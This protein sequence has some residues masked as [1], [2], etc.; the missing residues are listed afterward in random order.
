MGLDSITL[1]A[2]TH[3]ADKLP[4]EVSPHL[5]PLAHIG[6]FL[7]GGSRR[8]FFRGLTAI[9]GYVPADHRRGMER[10]LETRQL[11]YAMR[12]DA[13]RDANRLRRAVPPAEREAISKFFRA[14]RGA[15]ALR[16]HYRLLDPHEPEGE[17]TVASILDGTAF[18][19]GGL[20]SRL[21]GQRVQPAEV[22]DRSRQLPTYDPTARELRVGAVVMRRYGKPNYHE[23]ILKAFQKAEWKRRVPVPRFFHSDPDRLRETIDQLNTPQKDRRMLIRFRLHEKYIVW[24]WR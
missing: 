22:G 12:V 13:V 23:R 8:R 2:L 3:Y 16:E 7:T 6:L 20:V 15:R 19:S 17:E 14:L 18:R 9:F 24:E 10:I 21:L 4:T 5:G 11:D 1:P